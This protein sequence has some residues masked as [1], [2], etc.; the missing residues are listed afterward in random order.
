M[1]GAIESAIDIEV[2]AQGHNVGKLLVADA[3]R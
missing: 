2:A 3:Y 1:H